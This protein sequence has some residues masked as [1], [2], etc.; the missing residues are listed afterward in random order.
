MGKISKSY[1][2][3]VAERKK[4]QSGG[5]TRPRDNFSVKQSNIPGANNGLFSNT[6]MRKGQLI[7]LAHENNQPVGTLGN[8]H[9]HSESPNMRSVK[10]GN[11]RYLY[12]DR[13]IT[14]GEELTT[15]YRFQP[16]LEQPEDFSRNMGNNRF[17]DGGAKSPVIL[18]Q[19]DYDLEKAPKQGNFLLSDIDRPFYIDDEGWKRSEY[20]MGVNVDGKETLIP[21]VVNGTQ[22]TEDQ[23]IQRYY[24]TGLH[25]GQYNTVP[26]S[27]YASRMR[28]LKYNMLE[29]P[30]RF[31]TNYQTG[32]T[33]K[34]I[35]RY[36]EDRYGYNNT[37]DNTYVRPYTPIAKPV[38]AQQV[39]PKALQIPP[40]PVNRY[41]K[42]VD[43]TVY[44]PPV[45]TVRETYETPGQIME[46]FEREEAIK[47]TLSKVDGILPALD[48]TTD[49]MQMFNFIPFPVAQGIGKVG[50]VAGAAIDT[51]QG[52][53]ALGQ[54]DYG[55][56]GLN[57]GSALLPS[58]LQRKGYLRPMNSVSNYNG[59]YRPLN[60]LPWNNAAQRAAISPFI[61]ANRRVAGALVGETLYDAGLIPNNSFSSQ[62][63]GFRDN[64]QINNVNRNNL[65]TLDRGQFYQAGGTIPKYVEDRIRSRS[66]SDATAITPVQSFPKPLSVPTTKT[67]TNLGNN[68]YQQANTR[69]ETLIAPVS[70]FPKLTPAQML[71]QFE[72]AVQAEAEERQAQSLQAEREAAAKTKQAVEDWGDENATFT[73]PAGYLQSS[74]TTKA[75]KD[76]DWRE[77]AYVSGRNLGSWNAG[78]WTD[79]VNPVAMLGSMAEGLGSAPYVARET[80]SLMP[81][82][83]GIGSPLLAGAL[84]GL[85]TK[86]TGQFV[87]NLANPLAGINLNLTNKVGNALYNLQESLPTGR[88]KDNILGAS[89]GIHDIASGRPFFETFPITKKQRRAVE[90]AQDKA[91]E[92]GLEFVK[93][94]NYPRNIFTLRPEVSTRI[95]NIFPEAQGLGTN[96]QPFFKRNPIYTANNVLVNSKT[97]FLAKNPNISNEAKQYILSRRGKI[98][99]VNMGGT[100]ESITLRNHGFYYNPPS[101]IKDVAAHELGHSMQKL[102][103]DFGIDWG[104]QIATSHP[105]Y[106]Y[107]VANRN[108]PFGRYM[109]DAMVKPVKGQFTWEAS[110][111]EPHSELMVARMNVFEDLMRNSNFTPNQVMQLLQNPDDALTDIL[112]K[113]NNLD[114]FFEPTT[115]Q[116]VK[117][118]IVRALPVVGAGVLQQNLGQPSETTY[119]MG[120]TIGVPRVNGQVVS[121]GSYPITS[122]KKTRG[123]LKKDNKGNV[124]TMSNQQVKQVLKYSKQKPN[125]I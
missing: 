55:N 116:Q 24:D 67:P 79:Y 17:Q 84:G 85:G 108:T 66:T 47:N 60:Y 20:R 57:L 6:P 72:D 13:D 110:P 45:K 82:V 90:T 19:I 96:M 75:W 120:G 70:P 95:Q 4:Y 32:G 8:M 111:L 86:S 58:Y 49:I 103:T 41:R 73:F 121:S 61:N 124:K 93:E 62:F 106:K 44:N 100:D 122:V 28:T 92:E 69:D 1:L 31:D 10:I 40:T 9:N 14:P 59:T 3:E 26:E 98:G 35:P 51:Y 71:Q 25:M 77:K 30:V 48:V 33:K 117:R 42:Q 16:E 80:D 39:K 38:S 65:Y 112:I 29:D 21:T 56:A 15:N 46:E 53:R 114:R 18:P 12:A 37:T 101:R 64:T 22:L 27:E 23:A 36:V 78:N 99:G 91:F 74:G 105:D 52:I 89:K 119:Q 104:Q 97:S 76:M 88:I 43:N 54:G 94:W 107:L 11:Q 63:G 34:P 68:Y 115:S 125:K 113:R 50:N 5:F 118:N 102:G 87:N 83:T 2:K 123:S 81:Y 7:G 109:G